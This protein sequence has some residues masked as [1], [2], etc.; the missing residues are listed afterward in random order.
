M[1]RFVCS[2][3]CGSASRLQIFLFG[4]S[5]E[6]NSL[7]FGSDSLQ[8]MCKQINQAISGSRHFSLTLPVPAAPPLSRVSALLQDLFNLERTKGS[9]KKIQP[10]SFWPIFGC[11]PMFSLLASVTS[12]FEHEKCG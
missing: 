6:R 10:V 1:T 12:L 5:E 4:L 11:S 7:T 9:G 2:L 3:L 8:W